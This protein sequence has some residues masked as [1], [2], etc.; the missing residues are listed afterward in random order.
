[1]EIKDCENSLRYLPKGKLGEK[2]NVESI[3]PSVCI[4]IYFDTDSP[5]PQNDLGIYD[6]KNLKD[7]FL[8]LYNI[9]QSKQIGY[10]SKSMMIFYD[11]ISSLQNKN[12]DYLSQNQKIYMQKAHEYITSNYRRQNFDYKEL[13]NITGLKYSYF[14]ELFKKPYKATPVK[15]VTKM[16]IDYAKSLISTNKYSINEIAY[17]CGF[18]DIHYFYSVFKKETGFSPAKYPFNI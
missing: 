9:W 7:K 4:D 11:I 14:N 6:N 1:M 5:M 16:R 12:N 15:T 8:K 10:Y 2:Y 18:S 17:M 13:C 3:V